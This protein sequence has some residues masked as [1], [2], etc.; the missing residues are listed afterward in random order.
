MK[1]LGQNKK[2][3]KILLNKEEAIMVFTK[4]GVRVSA[5]QTLLNRNLSEEEAFEYVEK[6][7]PTLNIFMELMSY[8]DEKHGGNIK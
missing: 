5:P 2:G 8:L 4:D 6:S 3:T 1:I 7:N